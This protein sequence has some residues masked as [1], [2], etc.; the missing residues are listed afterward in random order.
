MI[1]SII[2]P[3]KVIR[4]HFKQQLFEY[5]NRIFNIWIRLFPSGEQDGSREMFLWKGTRRRAQKLLL[6]LLNVCSWWHHYITPHTR[7]QHSSPLSW[8]DVIAIQP[9]I[10]QGHTLSTR[11]EVAGLLSCRGNHAPRSTC[12]LHNVCGINKIDGVIAIYMDS[13]RSEYIN[14]RSVFKTMLRFFST[15]ITFSVS[16]DTVPYFILISNYDLKDYS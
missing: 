3:P 5:K 14:F 7:R 2:Q 8:C 6:V 11:V 1:S 16:I 4:Q 9:F 12:I 10:C 13:F 15:V